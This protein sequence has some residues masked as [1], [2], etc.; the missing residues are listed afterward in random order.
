MDYFQQAGVVSGVVDTQPFHTGYRRRFNALSVLWKLL[1]NLPNAD[2]IML[3]TSRGGT[4]FLAP[5]VFILARL[6]RKPFIFRPF[7]GDI[8]DYSK[9]FGRLASWIFRNTVLRADLLL[10]QTRE[11]ME[12]FAGYTTRTLHL[13]TCRPAPSARLIRADRPFQ[14]R[15]AFIG[16]VKL[17]KGVEEIIEAT[18]LLP[19]DYTVHM[20]GPFA[21]GECRQLMRSNQEVYRGQISPGDLLNTLATYD[22]LLLPTYYPGE[23]Y[24]GVI[25]EAFSLGLPVISTEWKAIPELVKHGENGL[26]I[27]P[28]SVEELVEAI[29]YFNPTNYHRFSKNAKLFF[30]NYLEESTVLDHLLKELQKLIS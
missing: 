15:F 24:P 27:Q 1:L 4:R 9:T 7:G 22:V 13:P 10:L 18:G 8:K 11:L 3:N 30:D 23:G 14:K 5:L 12:H 20:Y 19:Q 17:S 6:F 16:Q 28:R 2:L 29:L 21:G 25:I 26:L